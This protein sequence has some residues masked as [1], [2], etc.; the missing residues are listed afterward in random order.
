MRPE[1]SGWEEAKEHF[2]TTN[3]SDYSTG[4]TY[5]TQGIWNVYEWVR[6]KNNAD[7]NKTLEIKSDGTFKVKFF[8]SNDTLQ[9]GKWSWNGSKIIFNIKAGMT[10]RASGL[11]NEDDGLMGEGMEVAVFEKNK[12]GNIGAKGNVVKHIQFHLTYE[13]DEYLDAHDDNANIGTGAGCGS[14]PDAC[15]GNYGPKTK[16]LVKKWQEE[17]GV[18]ADGIWGKETTRMFFTGSSND[19]ED[20]VD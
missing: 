11:F 3:A 2:K 12:I 14:N 17:H 16:E 8:T 7:P 13:N 1:V 9:A 6:A 15:D 18:T 20:K 19:L 10:K 5:D 4:Y